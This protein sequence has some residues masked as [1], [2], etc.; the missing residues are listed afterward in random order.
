MSCYR[1]DMFKKGILIIKLT[2]NL[3]F[4]KIRFRF[5]ALT[6]SG[7]ICLGD[8]RHVLRIKCSLSELRNISCLTD[9]EDLLL[10]SPESARR[11]NLAIIQLNPPLQLISFIVNLPSTPRSTMWPLPFGVN[12]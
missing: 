8:V 9:P 11:P 7:F 5:V 6:S 3:G 10:C 4:Y 2:P 1:N 12:D